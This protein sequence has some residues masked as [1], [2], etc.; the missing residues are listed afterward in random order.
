MTGKHQIDGRSLG[1][2]LIVRFHPGNEV[3]DDRAGKVCTVTG[4]HMGYVGAHDGLPLGC[5]DDDDLQTG[6]MPW[7]QKQTD[8]RQNGFVPPNQFQSPGPFQFL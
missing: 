7:G 4:K 3:R 5:I 8:P 1:T 6:S 2:N